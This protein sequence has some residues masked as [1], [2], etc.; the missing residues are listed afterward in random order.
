M[1]SNDVRLTENIP[2]TEGYK[3]KKLPPLFGNFTSAEVNGVLGEA[4]TKLGAYEDRNNDPDEINSLKL[5]VAVLRRR[6][7]RLCRVLSAKPGAITNVCDVCVHE[8]DGRQNPESMCYDCYD[9][10]HWCWIGNIDSEV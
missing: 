3:L 1:E 9:D 10:A 8:W 4:I 2:G 6:I 5:E 7:V